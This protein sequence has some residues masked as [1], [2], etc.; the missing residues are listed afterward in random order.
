MKTNFKSFVLLAACAVVAS[1]NDNNFPDE[2]N[3]KNSLD[4]ESKLLSVSDGS[5][6]YQ[7]I[8]GD[9]LVN[10]E[11]Y[12]TSK[13]YHSD[14]TVPN[15]KIGNLK[16]LID[17]S[18]PSTGVDNWRNAISSAI[19]HWNSIPNSKIHFELIQSGVPDIT[20]KS[21]VTWLPNLPNTVVG[22]AIYP[23]GC[24]AG[25]TVA[26]N[27]DYNNNA[28]V[29]EGQKVFTIVH[30]LGHAIGFAHSD[31]MKSSSSLPPGGANPIQYQYY[32]NETDPSS[33]MISSTSNWSFSQF[34]L[35]DI[36]SAEALY[37]N[38]S[39]SIIYY[40]SENSQ[41]AYFTKVYWSTS[42]FCGELVR[43]KIYLNNTLV[44][45]LN[46]QANNGSY[47]LDSD[48]YDGDVR[49]EIYSQT[50]SMIFDTLNF[51]IYKD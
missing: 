26:I 30:E 49:F 8:E 48:Q 46:N 29:T 50:N 15:S 11:N 41:H 21:D 16:V 6:K 23:N 14:K 42:F 51:S 44:K 13:N 37:P 31:W 40:P 1:C 10:F 45:D 17:A 20:I 28:T 35:I 47:S 18:M 7:I 2:S 33:V 27:L 22:V 36:K 39:N 5:K 32:I 25:Q 9:I 3:N 4:S 43:I 34:S 19:G 38:N 12:S 24:N